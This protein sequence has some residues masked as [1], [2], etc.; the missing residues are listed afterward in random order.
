MAEGV[1]ETG[2]GVVVWG[3]KNGVRGALWV[4]ME[5]AVGRVGAEVCIDVIR[6]SSPGRK[7]EYGMVEGSKPTIIEQ[8]PIHLQHYT[9][10]RKKKIHAKTFAFHEAFKWRLPMR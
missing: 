1:E 4:L 9:N 3:G 7:C 10:S 6:R 5:E 8:C 2:E